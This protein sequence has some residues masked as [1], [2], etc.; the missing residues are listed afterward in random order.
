MAYNLCSNDFWEGAAMKKLSFLL[1]LLS[2]T[3]FS[4]GCTKTVEDEKQDVEAE[5]KEGAEEI[6][7]EQKDVENEKKEAGDEI[8]DEQKDVE[9][10]KKEAADEIRD[11]QK[12]VEKAETEQK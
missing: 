11:E 5:K 7:D 10:E 12:D 3:V 1:M 8:H 4:V 6:Q 9:A 2:L